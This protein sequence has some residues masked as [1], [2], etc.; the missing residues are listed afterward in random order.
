MGV[1][2]M[3]YY[4]FFNK[5]KA[6]EKKHIVTPRTQKEKKWDMQTDLPPDEPVNYQEE[7][8]D[9]ETIANAAKELKS[10]ME[11][12]YASRKRALIMQR[13]LWVMVGAVLVGGIGF[14]IVNNQKATQ[15]T[16]YTAFPYKYLLILVPFIAISLVSR[17]YAAQLSRYKGLEQTALATMVKKLFPSFT[18]SQGKSI[19]YAEIKKSRLFPWVESHTFQ[20]VFGQVQKET[21]MAKI[22][23][24]DIGFMDEKPYTNTSRVLMGIPGLNVIKS[25]MAKDTADKQL[26]TFRGLLC[27][28]SFNK[29]MDGTILVLPNNLN[30]TLNNLFASK[31]KE[32]KVSLEDQRFNNEFSVFA[33]DQ[34]EARYMLPSSVMEKIV[35][36]KHSF[37]EQIT[38]SFTDSNMYLSVKKTEG[39]FAIPEGKINNEN[40]LQQVVGLIYKILNMV[41]DLRLH[42]GMSRADWEDLQEMNNGEK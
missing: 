32:E 29:N 42:G 3:I 33:T 7:K 17:V 14:L 39:L 22:N 11:Q 16:D 20:T 10:A 21:P 24:A 4:M 15:A 36:L 12:V 34:I 8:P 28:I 23:F 25:F 26:Y 30:Q 2:S 18:F 5:S 1:V 6:T 19:P 35:E 13:G 37:G 40:F 41:D 38:L 31:I 9:S 27:R